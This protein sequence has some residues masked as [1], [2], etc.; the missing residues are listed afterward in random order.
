MLNK[1][2]PSL[3]DPVARANRADRTVAKQRDEPVYFCVCCDLLDSVA[4][5]RMRQVVV[6]ASSSTAFRSSRTDRGST[7][8]T[9]KHSSSSP[10]ACPCLRGSASFSLG[11]LPLGTSV[12]REGEEGSPVLL[13]SADPRIRD[14]SSPADTYNTMR[15][16]SPETWGDSTYGR[17]CQNR[18]N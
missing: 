5:R 17:P 4:R 1:L 14:R 3:I 16:R 13:F 12:T 18:V 10:T 11:F 9:S 6:D 2:R 7:A 15:S 8:T